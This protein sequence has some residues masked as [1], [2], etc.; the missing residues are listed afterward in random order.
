LKHP[1]SSILIFVLSV[2]AVVGIVLVSRYDYFKESHDFPSPAQIAQ[3]E[4][5][6]EKALGL[7][8]QLLDPL[9]EEFARLMA[10]NA[11]VP[12]EGVFGPIIVIDLS[13]PEGYYR[14][15]RFFAEDSLARAGSSG[16]YYAPFQ[17]EDLAKVKGIVVFT[18]HRF[19]IGRYT[20]G[21]TASGQTVHAAL[22]EWPSKKLLAKRTFSAGPPI[23]KAVAGPLGGSATGSIDTWVL[24]MCKEGQ[25]F[26]D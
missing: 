26:D 4:A 11:P 8:K 15:C 7:W 20:D 21:S 6:E 3:R 18:E 23:V 14:N 10:G 25:G 1:I 13:K 22:F 16:G 24:T 19:V 12:E 5:E 2:T 17:Y 9:R